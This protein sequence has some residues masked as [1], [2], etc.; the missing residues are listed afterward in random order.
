MR[1]LFIPYLE[2]AATSDTP[3][4]DL[5]RQRPNRSDPCVAVCERRSTAFLG[6]GADVEVKG[7]EM[8]GNSWGIRCGG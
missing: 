5:P 3:G 2:R 7:Q 1:P 8:V 6:K 4:W